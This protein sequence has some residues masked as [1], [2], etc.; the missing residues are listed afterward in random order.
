MSDY[1]FKRLD[2][3]HFSKLVPLYQN[4]FGLNLSPESIKN[5]FDA[6]NYTLKKNIAYVAFDNK[7]EAVALYALFPAL[8]YYKGNY[9]NS[10]QVGDLM[11]HSEHRRKGLFLELAELTHKLAENEGIDFIFTFPF[12]KNSSYSG[13]IKHLNF[14]HN[15]SFN[16]YVLKIN[17]LPICKLAHQ[18]NFLKPIYNFYIKLLMKLFY[19]SFSSFGEKEKNKEG[20]VLKD[21]KFFKYKFS[22]SKAYII[23]LINAKAWFKLTKF[24]SMSLGDLS[25]YNDIEKNLS[26]L[27]RFCFWAGI[28][29]IQIET[30][31]NTDFD[32]YLIQYSKPNNN[33]HICYLSLKNDIPAESFKFVFGDLDNF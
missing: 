20:H 10:A 32:N 9:Y 24:G 11:T 21:T 17:T 5:K 16:S 28:R 22:Y 33:Y 3:S 1:I 29:A 25:N 4:S 19:K 18:L 27:K 30:S 15:Q 6:F 7:G 2:E 26:S 14:L 8:I 31:A 13:F 12:G 23:N